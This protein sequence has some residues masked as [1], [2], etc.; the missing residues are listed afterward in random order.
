MTVYREYTDEEAWDI[1]KGNNEQ[2]EEIESI[3]DVK[4]RWWDDIHMILKYKP[5]GEFFWVDFVKLNCPDGV[6]K[7]DGVYIKFFK[8]HLA[9]VKIC[10]WVI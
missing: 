9:E 8:T 10:T 7:F 3:I 5:T 6:E 1:I 4:R 2:W